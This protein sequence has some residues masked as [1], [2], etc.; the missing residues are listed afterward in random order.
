M[1]QAQLFRLY[2]ISNLTFNGRPTIKC[3][4]GTCSIGTCTVNVYRFN[5]KPKFRIALSELD[6]NSI[7]KLRFDLSLIDSI[8]VYFA[9]CSDPF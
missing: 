2:N 5:A 8:L 6:C 1:F 9:D 7:D 3:S 4:I